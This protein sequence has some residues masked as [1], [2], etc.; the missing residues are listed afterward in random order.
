MAVI[1]VTRLR[2]QQ[3]HAADVR[4]TQILLRGVGAHAVEGDPDR[5]RAFRTVM[6]ES[7]DPVGRSVTEAAA[8]AVVS[9]ALRALEECNR[10][11]ENY[12][13]AGGKGL[14]WNGE[15]ADCGDCRIC[16][17]GRSEFQ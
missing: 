6:E 1:S 14:A 10:G 9:A 4:I 12:L 13:H 8:L 3:D 17:G 7:A 2:N 15:D 16:R 5:F 11:A